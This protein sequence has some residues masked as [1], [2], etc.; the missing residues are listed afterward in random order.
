MMTCRLPEKCVRA[1][2]S[3]RRDLHEHVLREELLRQRE[4]R[5]PFPSASP[6][7]LFGRIPNWPSTP[8][9]RF[10]EEQLM[11]IR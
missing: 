10:R 7:R 1:F 6:P 5:V 2:F 8:T 9:S 11:S 4:H 3:R